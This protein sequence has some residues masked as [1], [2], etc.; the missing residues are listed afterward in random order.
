MYPA[1]HNKMALPK[2]PPISF[3]SAEKLAEERRYIL[4]SYLQSMLTVA[5]LQD[6]VAQFIETPVEILVPV[7]KK[8]APVT[9]DDV[10][11]PQ[12]PKE[13]NDATSNNL[14]FILLFTIL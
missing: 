13:K 7:K 10:T 11:G 2:A 8:E 4:Q 1:L 3:K 14:L 12:R 5:C 6:L 9:L